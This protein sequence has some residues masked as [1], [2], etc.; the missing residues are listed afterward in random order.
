MTSI[1]GYFI[2]SILFLAAAYFIIAWSGFYTEMLRATSKTTYQTLDGLRGFLALAV[3]FHHGVISFYY[4]TT[5]SWKAPPS[6]FYTLTGQVAVSIFFMITGFLFWGKVVRSKGIL[7]T[8]AL[9]AS[10]IRRLVPAYAFSVLCVFSVVL[11]KSEAILH[12]PLPQLA[13]ELLSWLTF[14]FAY[15]LDINGIKETRVIN[16]VFWTLAY[17]WGFYLLLPFIASFYRVGLFAL[18]SIITI[19]YVRFGFA[20]AIVLNFLCGALAVYVINNSYIQ[21]FLK[22]P[23]NAFI[24]FVVLLGFFSVFDSGYGFKQ[25]IILFIFFI[26]VV[27]G[28][29]LYG[30][31]TSAQARFLGVIS[32]SLYLLHSIVLYVL[33]HL[34]NEYHKISSI[35][36]EQFWALMSFS[37]LL[38]ISV[39]ALSYRYIEY[40]FLAL[41]STTNN[42]RS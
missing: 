8:R 39:S 2:L 37:G 11:F 26:F 20:N 19:A 4:F 25:S 34:F 22:K 27:S 1:L 41:P 42:A 6:I 13:T 38:L 3:F 9:Y 31:L 12:V 30:L 23:I 24:P 21:N 14:G 15:Q 16:F 36:P 32:Y 17:E 28:N 29:T 5:D 10:R 33:F 40:P 18:L 35:A 7:D